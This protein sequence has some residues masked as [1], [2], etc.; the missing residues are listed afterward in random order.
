MKIKRAKTRT[1]GTKRTIGPSFVILSLPYFIF[2]LSIFGKF[3]S[4]PRRAYTTGTTALFY[5]VSCWSLA[6]QVM[7]TILTEH[8]VTKAIVVQSKSYT[9]SF[10]SSHSFS[11]WRNW[12]CVFSSTS[13]FSLNIMTK[14]CK[15]REA[16]I[17][18]PFPDRLFSN[19]DG[20]DVV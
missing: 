2:S 19:L 10:N 6:V 17:S 1:K 3:S 5:G 15:T 11:F 12:R 4:R 18:E 14:L 13:S 20:V 8:Y 7:S 16:A 9:F